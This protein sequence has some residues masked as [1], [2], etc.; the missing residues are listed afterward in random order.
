MEI[1]PETYHV[2]STLH[3]TITIL[4]MRPRRKN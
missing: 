1:T 2:L 3:D 4:R